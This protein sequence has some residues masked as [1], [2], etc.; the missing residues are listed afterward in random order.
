MKTPT[1][2]TELKRF[3]GSLNF[4]SKFTNKLHIS[5]EPFCTLLHDD[6]SIKRTPE[7][8]IFFRKIKTSFSKETERAIPKTTH[9]LYITVDA[10]LIGLGALLFQP[11]TD[12]KMQVVS[13]NSRISTTQEQKLSTFDRRLCAIT[14]ALSQYEFLVIGTKFPI[15]VFTDHKPIALLFTRKENLTPG[16]YKA[17]MLL[18]NSLTSKLFTQPEQI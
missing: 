1:S 10:S 18:P 15:T 12:N 16:Q 11:N 3:I 5:L 13:Y 17:Q 6:I 2:K 7:L 4:Y 8:D 9:L 14:F